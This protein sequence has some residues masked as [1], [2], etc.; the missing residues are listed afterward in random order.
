MY[1]KETVIGGVSLFIKNTYKYL[2]IDEI[3]ISDEVLETIIY[4]Y[5]ER[6]FL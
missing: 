5:D 1:K 6:T 4:Q 2:S 3:D